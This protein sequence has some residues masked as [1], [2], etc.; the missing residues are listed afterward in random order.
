MKRMRSTEQFTFFTR[1]FLFHSSSEK[2]SGRHKDSVGNSADH[3]STHSAIG[4]HEF[5]GQ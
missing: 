4:T 1:R 5:F 3:P 2:S